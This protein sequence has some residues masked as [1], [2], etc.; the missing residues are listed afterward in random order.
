VFL[1][2]WNDSPFHLFIMVKTLMSNEEINLVTKLTKLWGYSSHHWKRLHSFLIP[3][4]HYNK[5][6]LTFPTFTLYRY[7]ECTSFSFNALANTYWIRILSFTLCC[8]RVNFL[9]FLIYFMINFSFL[10]FV[11]IDHYQK[12]NLPKSNQSWVSTQHH[13]QHNPKKTKII[14]IVYS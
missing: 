1:S 3:L 8:Q 7:W 5:H 14:K 6:F 10:S 9:L 13:E 4:I 2:P 11:D 12:L